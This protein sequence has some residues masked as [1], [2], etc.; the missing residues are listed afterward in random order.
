MASWVQASCSVGLFVAGLG[1]FAD[2]E[3]AKPTM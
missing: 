3:E 1:V 2:K